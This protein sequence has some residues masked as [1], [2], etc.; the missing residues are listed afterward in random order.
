MHFLLK[1][2]C[3]T[4]RWT[5]I[6]DAFIC[7]AK[8]LENDSRIEWLR[9]RHRFLNILGNVFSVG[10]RTSITSYR[11]FGAKRAMR[12]HICEHYSVL[13]L[14]L[15]DRHSTNVSRVINGISF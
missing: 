6:Y 5:C 12:I 11:T 1:E 3:Q 15:D 13:S 4:V 8:H 2:D 10:N 14:F 7:T 9:E